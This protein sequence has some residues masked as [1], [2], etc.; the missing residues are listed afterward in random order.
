M[1][2]VPVMDR[3]TG[4]MSAGCCTTGHCARFW[5]IGALRHWLI[6]KTGKKTD[7]FNAEGRAK[8]RVGRDHL[9]LF[10][11]KRVVEAGR[12]AGGSQRR[13]SRHTLSS[14]S[15]LGALSLSLWLG[16]G[17]GCQMCS[18]AGFEV[19]AGRPSVCPLSANSVRHLS[20]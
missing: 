3:C 19:V 10:G 11:R 12:E 9:I 2:C 20:Q 14:F 16:L 15:G 5:G 18:W 7:P 8:P 17:R 4:S 13:G 6:T 1:F